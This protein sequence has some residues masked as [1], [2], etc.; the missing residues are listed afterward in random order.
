[1]L[2]GNPCSC[3]HLGLRASTQGFSSQG[4]VCLPVP[5]LGQKSDSPGGLL[6]LGE[7]EIMMEVSW[8]SMLL[9]ARHT[10]SPES[11]TDMWCSRRREP[12]A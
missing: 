9:L 1:M 7:T 5:F 11:A 10:Y 6:V 3:L 12:W 2:F 8:A 4:T